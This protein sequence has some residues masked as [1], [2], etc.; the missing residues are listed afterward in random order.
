M[1]VISSL[2][3]VIY[4]PIGRQSIDLLTYGQDVLDALSISTR[5]GVESIAVVGSPWMHLTSDGSVSMSLDISP[6]W[7]FETVDAAEVFISKLVNELLLFSKGVVTYQHAFGADNLPSLSD[8]YV[9]IVDS[10]DIRPFSPDTTQVGKI[11]RSLK[12]KFILSILLGDSLPALDLLSI[13]NTYQ[14]PDDSTMP[15]FD[16]I[17]DGSGGYLLNIGYP[18][19]WG[20]GESIDNPATPDKAGCVFTFSGSQTNIV[21]D[22]YQIN[23]M[24]DGKISYSHGDPYLRNSDVESIYA[25]KENPNFEGSIYLNGRVLDVGGSWSGGAVA[26]ATN[27]NS[28]VEF[29]TITFFYGV[30]NFQ[31]T[32]MFNSTAYFNGPAYIKNGLTIES[33]KGIRFNHNG[34][35]AVIKMNENGDILINGKK[36]ITESVS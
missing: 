25:K 13:G 21:Y 17:S 4:K 8:S 26:N 22:Y 12:I 36:I 6:V 16:I 31:N 7:L 28:R 33:D 20:N 30:A 34:I 32:A 14:L 1:D 23:E 5:T 11:C 2:E 15:K 19:R 3:S 29:N 27:F 9:A 35:E 18:A 24:L 10:V